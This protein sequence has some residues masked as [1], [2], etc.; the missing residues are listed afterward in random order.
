VTLVLMIAWLCMPLAVLAQTPPSGGPVLSWGYQS[1]P[2][3]TNAVAVS[4]GFHQ[5]FALLA[6]GTAEAG[7]DTFGLPPLSN[8]VGVAAGANDFLWVK[9]DG[10]VGAWGYNFY[11]EDNVPAGLSN[12]V[13]VAAGDLFSVALRADGSV[14]AWG[15]D[16]IGTIEQANAASGI[17]AI[18]ASCADATA[19]MGLRA[20]GTVVGWGSV[21]APSGLTNITKMALGGG[22]FMALRKD[23]TIVAWG[24]DTYGQTDVPPGLSN[25]TAIACGS[26]HSVAL[27]ADGTIVLWGDNSYGQSINPVGLHNVTAIAAGAYHTLVISDGEPC[28]LQWPSNQSVFTGMPVQFSSTATGPLPIGYQWSLN[29]NELVNATNAFLNLTNV[30]LADAGSYSL[31]ATNVYG[32]VSISAALS[33]TASPP[34]VVQQPAGETVPA[35]S[36][37]TFTVSTVGSW[38]LTFQWQVNSTNIPEATNAFLNLPNIQ[39]AQS[40]PY[41]VVISNSIGVSV[42]SNANLSVEPALVSIDPPNLT[43]NG[44]ATVTLTAIVV[45]QPALTFQWQFNGTNLPG[46]TNTAYVITNALDV[47]SGGYT[48]SISNEFGVVSSTASVVV[49][50]WVAVTISPNARILNYAPAGIFGT[51]GGFSQTNYSWQFN[52][53]PWNGPGPGVVAFINAAISNAGTYSLTVSD[54]YATVTSPGVT[55]TVIPLA[56]LTQPTNAVAWPGGSAAFQ[57]TAAGGTPVSYQ[58]RLDGTNIPGSTLNPLTL[59]NLGWE[60][61]GSYDVVV[62]NAYTTLTSS[63]ANL[64]LSEI[65]VWGDNTSGQTSL[66]PGLTNVMAIAQNNYLLFTNGIVGSYSSGRLRTYPGN[67]GIAIVAGGWPGYLKSDGTAFWVSFDGPGEISGVSNAVQIATQGTTSQRLDLEVT[68]DGRAIGKAAISGL[69]NIV[70][71]AT[72][73]FHCL[74][75]KSDGTVAT[76]GNQNYGLLNIPTAAT[77]VIG[78]AA[79][80]NHSLVLRSDGTVVAWGLNT[81]G[82]TRVPL[83]L[84]NVVAIAGGSAHSLALRGDGTLVAWGLNNFG[85]TNVPVGLANVVAIAAAGGIN[86]ALVGHRPMPQKVLL[87]RVQEETNALS[88]SLPTQSGRVYALEFKNALSDGGWTILPLVAGNGT[89]LNLVDVGATNSHRFYRVLRW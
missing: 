55:F 64:F 65:A 89:L 50:P 13:A 51:V 31:L 4:G 47:Q 53:S 70:S 39:V 54:S 3:I 81:S 63:V 30:G 69:S 79:G 49:I 82:Q 41:C 20:D 84:S 66:P 74:A 56:I 48:V 85:Q 40:G 42:S 38:P 35:G 12:V 73:Q 77:N 86:Y 67:F 87:S 7:G 88:C 72:G 71:V 25:V 46:A 59:T 8:I 60:Q 76:W 23:G 57:V 61:F 43:T 22:H 5:S 18:A 36:N 68:S 2:N 10:T 75:L 9:A 15:N 44:A 33:V 62:S 83:G 21:A 28:L 6:D 78:I 52:G 27:K 37:V 58:W 16:P 45:G 34:I 11:G 80:D 32:T 17:I 19:A 14:V 1:V 26:S 24:V 29:G